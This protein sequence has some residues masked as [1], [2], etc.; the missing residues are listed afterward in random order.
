MRQCLKKLNTS[1]IAPNNNG[2]ASK[3]QLLSTEKTV[4]TLGPETSASLE[5]KTLTMSASLSSNS[6]NPSNKPNSIKD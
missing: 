2:T 3:K 4:K 6:K 1:S 5:K